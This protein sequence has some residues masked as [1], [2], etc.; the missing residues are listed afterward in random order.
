L[1]GV[2]ENMKAVEENEDKWKIGI[3]REWG[4][5][6]GVYLCSFASKSIMA[7]DNCGLK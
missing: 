6:S 4:G 7:I 1:K 5:G 3:W 2:K